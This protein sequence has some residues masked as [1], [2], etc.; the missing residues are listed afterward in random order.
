M[1]ESPISDD[2]WSYRGGRGILEQK[3]LLGDLPIIAEAYERFGGGNQNM[4]DR[5]GLMS[6]IGWQQEVSARF[7]APDSEYAR[8]GNFDAY[9]DGILLEHES[10]EQMRANWH[11]MK[12]E[13][14]N[15]DP[16]SLDA[17][18]P[19]E[20][21]VLLIPGYV[22]FPTLNRTKTDMY[23]FLAN[24]FGFSLPL[25]VWQYPTEG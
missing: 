12:M 22:R 3:G 4:A 2:T 19:V 13:A 21:G 9:K 1:V 25:L 7:E 18:D 8:R 11:L 5:E 17:I 24:Y 10:G 6:P 15:R 23:A 14:V 16:R 20:A